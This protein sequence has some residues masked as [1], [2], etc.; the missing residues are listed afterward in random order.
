MQSTAR[1]AAMMSSLL[2]L[3]AIFACSAAPAPAP[4]DDSAP[5]AKKTTKPDTSN[6]ADPTTP[7]PAA[8]AA[9]PPAGACGTKGTFDMCFDCCYAKNP[10][11][12]DKSE[13]VFDDCICVAPGAC[14]ADCADTFCGTDPSKM[15]SAAC[16]ACLN[17]NGQ[18]CDDKAGAAC[19]ASAG[20]K[21][22]DDC[23][24]AQCA[25]LDK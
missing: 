22:V 1:L 24:A 13:V 16:E 4:S 23:M 8:D 10:T 19:S 9:T 5:A 18:A 7:T 12:Y 11:E 2:A 20:C 6:D 17:T 21:E 15:P 25:P 3:T 14:K